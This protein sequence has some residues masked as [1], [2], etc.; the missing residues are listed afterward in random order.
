MTSPEE[1]SHQEEDTQLS[2]EE[3]LLSQDPD[4]FWRVCDRKDREEEGIEGGKPKRKGISSHQEARV[5][6]QDLL[7]IYFQLSKSC[8]TGTITNKQ[9]I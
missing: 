7:S 3:Q 5:E 2:E 6:N 9:Y 8:Q 4:M 1:Q